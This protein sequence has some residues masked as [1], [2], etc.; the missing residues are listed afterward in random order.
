LILRQLQQEGGA[1]LRA[2]LQQAEREID[3]AA[4]FTIHGFCA[5][6]LAEHALDTGQAFDAPE[7]IGSD[8]PLHD[9]LA[10]DLWRGFGADVL[11]AQLLPSLW[12]GPKALAKDL[13]A[14]LRAQRL[15]RSRDSLARADS[16]G[17]GR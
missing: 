15:L 3:L 4:V 14:L 8:R 7:M 6:A 12:N 16:I 17:D 5:R 2:R 13:G 1:S 10:A 11:D 9:E